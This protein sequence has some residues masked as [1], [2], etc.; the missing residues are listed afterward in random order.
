MIYIYFIMSLYLVWVCL[1][2]LAAL[3]GTRK[4]SRPFGGEPTTA[5]K[6]SIIVPVKNESDTLEESLLS[7]LS[8]DYPNKEIIVVYGRSTDNTRDILEK[9]KHE[10]K[11]IE[12]PD[13]PRGW[14]GKPW[15]C[16]NGFLNSSGEILLFTDGDVIHSNK[17]LSHSMSFIEK[18]NV[19]FLSVWPK[20]FA[21]SLS[22]KIILP[23]GYFLLYGAIATIA[24]M[25][26]SKGRVPAAANGQYIIVKRSC[27]VLIGGHMSV[28]SEIIEDAALARLA[29]MKGFNV[30]NIEAGR[31]LITKPYANFREVW[32]NL[33]RLMAGIAPSFRRVLASNIIIFTYF[34]LPIIV[35]AAGLLLGKCDLLSLGLVTSSILF[36]TQA[37]FYSKIS[38]LR[39]SI[40]AP[41]AGGI[42]ITIILISYIK[43]KSGRIRW[44][45]VFYKGGSEG[46]LGR[47]TT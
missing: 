21:R 4:L 31:L 14:V 45:G 42:L 33:Q 1:V 27:Y 36:G 16:Y 12:E 26:T 44:K 20:V 39:Y 8:L 22:E 6:V 37:Y 35:F 9:F 15:A 24:S 23:I 46:F 11:I 41:L 18:N 10:I 40:F 19:D 30:V 47:A 2:S 25:G 32:E 43:F 7:L 28:R 13:K 17:S 34:I 3:A 29:L 38:S 5:P